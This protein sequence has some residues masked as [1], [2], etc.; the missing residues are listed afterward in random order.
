MRSRLRAHGGLWAAAG[1]VTTVGLAFGL[2]WFQPW[3]LWTDTRVQDTLPTVALEPNPVADITSKAPASPSRT[4]PSP[5]AISPSPSVATPGPTEA[6]AKPKA[7]LLSRGK[8]ISHE[9][10]TSGTVSI[11]A[12][13]DGSRVLA[14]S[15]LDTS[16]GPD[17]EVWLTD[18]PVLAG[19]K[20]W[21]VFDDGR[22]HSLGDLRGN[23]GNLVYRIPDDLDLA[24][25]SS[26]SLW[27]ARFDVSFG[28]ARLTR[29]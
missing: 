8:L 22:H 10:D 24:R 13:P 17:V 23:Q 16:D 28:A 20:G 4:L 1:F 19:A 7:T 29:V 2:Y 21:Y 18:A 14:I 3:K 15:D 26:V 11:V 5:S 9:H 12:Q 27:C 25:Y 6:P